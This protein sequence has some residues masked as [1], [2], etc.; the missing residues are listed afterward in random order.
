MDGP[1][2][3]YGGTETVLLV[4]DESQIRETLAFALRRSGYLV[5]VADSGEDAMRVAA[6]HGAPIHLLLSDVV[7]PNID[8]C[9]LARDFRRWSPGIGVLLMSG[10]PGGQDA[11]RQIH[12]N[13]VF[14]IDKPF[15][16]ERLLAAVRAAIDWRP[17]RH[18]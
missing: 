7:M 17:A 13:S 14:V 1:L 15:G 5:L 2:A 12:D 6:E 8:G 18:G 11:A 4:D 10:Y 16:M 3:D 9:D